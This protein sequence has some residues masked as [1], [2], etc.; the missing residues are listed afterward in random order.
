MLDAATASDAPTSAPADDESITPDA[1]LRALAARL[2]SNPFATD[3]GTDAIRKAGT[4]LAQSIDRHRA[5]CALAA[6]T[7]TVVED[8][9]CRAL[10]LLTGDR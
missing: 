3:R 5:A 8:L 1:I 7:E 10:A 4:A 2:A 6:S 9:A